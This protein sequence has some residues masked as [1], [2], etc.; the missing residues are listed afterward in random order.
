MRHKLSFTSVPNSLHARWLLTSISVVALFTLSNSV[1]AQGTATGPATSHDIDTGPIVLIGSAGSPMPIDLDPTGQPWTKGFFD[2]K[3]L[4]A[5]DITVDIIETIQNVGTESWGDW[6]EHIIG[7]P[8][9]ATFPSFWSSVVS[10]QINGSPITFIATGI[11]TKDLWLDTF[12]QPV[13]PGD[14]LTIHKQVDVFNNTAGADGFP[15]IRLQEYPTPIPE[16]G[17]LA[18]VAVGSLVLMVMRR[19]C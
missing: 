4:A 12:S 17:S 7:D 3:I 9:S 2:P 13:L 19:R 5:G 14:I 15:L 8:A 16:P 1:L 18:L 6:H 10:I 11:G